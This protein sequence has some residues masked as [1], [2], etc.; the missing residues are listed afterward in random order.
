M[1]VLGTTL[2]LYM[3]NS[4]FT[5]VW[6]ICYCLLKSYY[7]ICSLFKQLSVNSNAARLQSML[8]ICCKMCTKRYSSK[9]C[10]QCKE[11]EATELWQRQIR[12]SQ[13]GDAWVKCS[14]E[15]QPLSLLRGFLLQRGVGALHHLTFF[16]AK[17]KKA[18]NE[19]DQQ[20][21]GEE[22]VKDHLWVN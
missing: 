11:S 16:K 1:Y 4:I 8:L 21:H 5:T 14:G 18:I 19:K 10:S 6:G 17:K 22:A 3:T 9:R 2:G 7:Y 15:T 13:V 12:S 20:F